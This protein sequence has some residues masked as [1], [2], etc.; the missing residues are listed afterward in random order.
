MLFSFS[1]YV[2]SGACVTNKNLKVFMP[3]LDEHSSH[4]LLV[5]AD[6]ALRRFLVHDSLANVKDKS[7]EALIAHAVRFMET[8]ISTPTL[9]S[10]YKTLVL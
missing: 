6:C 4:W 5:C 8:Y 3:L 2:A 1:V 9:V 7:R 10:M